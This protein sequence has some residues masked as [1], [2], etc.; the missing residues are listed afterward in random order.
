MRDIENDQHDTFD[1]QG[2]TDYRQ[3]PRLN[4]S[5]P[6]KSRAT[7][8]DGI[9]GSSGV[10]RVNKVALCYLIVLLVVVGLSFQHHVSQSLKLQR[11]A[12][13]R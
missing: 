5:E 8:A 12:R 11:L 10:R 9:L 1:S 4:L 6:W 3:S 2:K 7:L 13:S